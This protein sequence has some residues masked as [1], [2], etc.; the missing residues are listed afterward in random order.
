MDEREPGRRI[1]Y[2]DGLRALAV[3]LVVAHHLV[4]HEPGLQLPIPFLS[5]AH[6]LLDG[7]HGVD[8]FFVLSGFCLSYPIL[9]HLQRDGRA[10]F[11]I[12]HY[13]AKRLVR[14]VPPYYAALALFAAAGALTAGR[15]FT[16][17]DIVKQMLFL[18]W[19][20]HFVNGSFWTLAI[21]FRWYFLFPIALALWIARPRAFIAVAF[22]T[23]VLYN[24]TRLH[25]PDVGTLLPFLLGIVAADLELR[26]PRLS[27]LWLFALPLCALFGLALEQGA[28]MPSPDGVESHLFYVQTNLGWQLTMFAFVVAAGARRT[29][30]SILS[31]KPL[32]AVGTASYSIYLVHEP[33]VAAVER[34]TP[35]PLDVRLPVAYVSA[36]LAGFAF[37][38]AFE[39]AWTLGSMRAR[40]IAVVEPRLRAAARWLQIPQALNFSRAPAC[41]IA[42]PIARSPEG[43]RG[44]TVGTGM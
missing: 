11:A 22:G 34:F 5:T 20:T 44:N 41:T 29:L 27:P 32:V 30:R 7:S 23:A 14:I 3:L 42:T 12:D 4:R 26:A 40:G 37:W 18:D 13:A 39:R 8:L 33:V 16:V 35:L 31:F 28:S 38:Y 36:V 21:E 15:N 24:F 9:A 19:H 2:V 17:L 43:A 10:R 1:A 6:L 25:A